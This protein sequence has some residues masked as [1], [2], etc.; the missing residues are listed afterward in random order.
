L[1]GDSNWNPIYDN[2]DPLK[3]IEFQAYVSPCC[4]LS[5]H[6]VD[7]PSNCED[8]ISYDKDGNPTYLFEEYLHEK[9]DPI[10]IKNNENPDGTAKEQIAL[11]S[12][13]RRFGQGQYLIERSGSNYEYDNTTDTE[14][15]WI[16]CIANGDFN[17]LIEN[18][19]NDPNACYNEEQLCIAWRKTVEEIRFTAW[20][21]NPN[22]TPVYGYH[23]FS[24]IPNFKESFDLLKAFLDKTGT[25]YQGFTN[26]NLDDHDSPG[27]SRYVRNAYKQVHFWN[28]D[29]NYPDAT[30]FENDLLEQVE[31]IST[32]PEL[33]SESAP[34]FPLIDANNYWISNSDVC[35][36]NTTNPYVVDKT[37]EAIWNSYY[38]AKLNGLDNGNHGSD[39]ANREIA[40]IDS[41]FKTGE[42]GVL[43]KLLEINC[44]EKGNLLEQR[45]KE[46]YYQNG[47]K[48]FDNPFI[49]Y[50][51]N[52]ILYKHFMSGDVVSP[53][54]PIP[55]FTEEQLACLLE[56]YNIRCK[57]LSLSLLDK[58]RYFKNDT[59]FDPENQPGDKKVLEEYNQIIEEYVNL[60]TN[61][62]E[63]L[64]ED[65]CEPGCEG[66]CFTLGDGSLYGA[67][68]GIGFEFLSKVEK[69][70]IKSEIFSVLSN[71]YTELE[72][73]IT[74]PAKND[75]FLDLRDVYIQH[76]SLTEPIDQKH[77]DII[78][79]YYS[80]MPHI[81]FETIKQVNDAIIEFNKTIE[82]GRCELI[83]KGFDYTIAA[84]NTIFQ[85]SDEYKKNLRK[86]IN[87]IEDF[88]DG[89]HPF[90]NHLDHYDDRVEAFDF[91]YYNNFYEKDRIKFYQNIDA[92]DFFSKEKH[93]I[94]PRFGRLIISNSWGGKSLYHY[95]INSGEVKLIE[96]RVESAHGSIIELVDKTD[97]LMLVYLADWFVP[98]SSGRDYYKNM[99]SM[100]L[101]GFPVEDSTAKRCR[102][103]LCCRTIPM[104]PEPR[105]P[106]DLVRKG[107]DGHKGDV[108]LNDLRIQIQKCKEDLDFAVDGFIEE[109]ERGEFLADLNEELVIEYTE[110]QKYHY[111]LYYYDRQGNLTKT[112]PPRGVDVKDFHL[113]TE[114]PEH[115]FLSEYA[116]D[117]FGNVTEKKSPD[118]TGDTKYYYNDFGQLRFSQ[119][120]QQL[121]ESKY[122]YTIYDDLGR[123]IEVGEA[124]NTNAAKLHEMV[125]I[126]FNQDAPPSHRTPYT[127]Q[128]NITFFVMTVYDEE[129]IAHESKGASGDRA[130]YADVLRLALIN[131]PDECPS[132]IYSSNVKRKYL[133][134]RINFVIRDEDGQCTDAKLS[135]DESR[136]D[137]DRTITYYSYDIHGNVDFIV[138]NVPVHH[139]KFDEN[140]VVNRLV[141][142]TRY[143]YDLISGK[144][145]E[146][147]Y[148]DKLAESFK[149]KYEYDEQ[150][151]LVE[152]K[153]SRYG[154]FWES[155]ARYYYY[156]HGPLRRVEMGEDQLQG[157]DY[158]YTING[159]LKA[160]NNSNKNL[161]EPGSDGSVANS[162]DANYLKYPKDAFGY[163]LNYN[164]EDYYRLND[165]YSLNSDLS[166][167]ISS[168]ISA[169]SR[170]L[171]FPNLYNGNIAAVSYGFG[172]DVISKF[173]PNLNPDFIG[174]NNSGGIH[175][176]FQYDV[177]NRLVKSYEAFK[178]SSDFELNSD[179]RYY[180]EYEYDAS[181]N[182]LELRRN[183]FDY[184]TDQSQMDNL[185]YI[186][187]NNKNQLH[188]VTE[189]VNHGQT[190]EIKDI[191]PIKGYIDPGGG[192]YLYDNIGNLTKDAYE[193]LDEITWTPDGKIKSYKFD[194][195]TPCEETEFKCSIEF[196]YDALGNRVRKT[197][198]KGLFEDGQHV[199][200]PDP[201]C[202]D[203]DPN[204]DNLNS[205][206]FTNTYYARGANGK[207]KA[208]YNLIYDNGLHGDFDYTKPDHFKDEDPTDDDIHY[209]EYGV[210][211][212]STNEDIPE[213]E[214]ATGTPVELFTPEYD[215]FLAIYEFYLP[216][217]SE[218][219]IYGSGAQGRFA[220]KK[221]DYAH[222][223]YQGP[224][225]LCYSDYESRI[226]GLKSY[227]ITD[228]LGNPRVIL[229]DWR[230][231]QYTFNKLAT[232]PNISHSGLGLMLDP[233]EMNNYFPF[234]MLKEGMFAKSGNG[235]RY[236]FNGM[237]RDN[238]TKGFGNDLSTFFRGY[239]PRLGRWK[240]VDPVTKAM[241]SAYVGFG[242]NPIVFIDPRGD[243]TSEVWT[244]S[245]TGEAIFD[246]YGKD[247]KQ[248]D[249]LTV[250]ADMQMGFNHMG[251]YY[252]NYFFNET[253]VY[254][255]GSEFGDEGWYSEEE[256]EYINRDW[257][258]GQVLP[259]LTWWEAFFS[260]SRKWE[261]YD[262]DSDGYLTGTITYAGTPPDVTKGGAKRAG[263]LLLKSLGVTKKYGQFLIKGKYSIYFY[264][265]KEGKYYIG[266]ARNGVIARYGSKKAENLKV[267]TFE[268][269]DLTIK[270]NA[271]ALGVEQA[272]IKLNGGAI[273]TNK[274]TN[275]VNKIN[276]T[277]NNIY[278]RVGEKWLDKN[279]K[280]WR[281]KFKLT[282]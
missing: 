196:T 91:Q 177:L 230:L 159:W 154:K 178:G 118:E 32:D 221:P 99:I 79:Y 54:D 51:G 117:S 30:Y 189:S 256:Y 97:H 68:Q 149:H 128:H 253:R 20:E 153:T 25:F 78:R 7:V 227:E 53:P 122:S 144:V 69:K 135:P 244:S 100:P 195:L 115:T 103:Q 205:L 52:R 73:S 278:R 191:D 124:E 47:Y 2:D 175:N 231:E 280:D 228:H 179:N 121:S 270:N 215:A 182:I 243:D 17:I 87:D 184:G 211:D 198:I 181:G 1:E 186:Y 214:T 267:V 90:D 41:Y 132:D 183:V 65:P 173:S 201:C 139:I 56:D 155:D 158:T 71:R 93:L 224:P 277:V 192:Y 88:L 239:D 241:E 176:L 247:A 61:D 160:V 72:E 48:V 13:F 104:Q 246:H 152:V 19:L 168:T 42:L 208:V 170:D 249:M 260:E 164:N 219:Y 109:I 82:Q 274:K 190:F 24:E 254:H 89:N 39:E 140:K 142:E 187:N 40:E 8:L 235:Y 46:F 36:F 28:N 197:L 141:T 165:N 261:G 66:N 236:G 96:E 86:Y 203:T 60:T 172:D 4:T 255:E 131:N 281:T 114:S 113:L 200:Y 81:R 138:Q 213:W 38:A 101:L 169:G 145:N 133:R 23:G 59:N 266:K 33:S 220:S 137:Y 94:D 26:A 16:D 130:H 162:I 218:W 258:N 271:T 210:D 37:M 22:G 76:H 232:P 74:D 156:P 108:I 237:E 166:D 223:L 157:L 85:D 34:E 102:R 21:V 188:K 67:V 98:E 55:H 151:R 161:I 107:V 240:S 70:V 207:V 5:I 225:D 92:I 146:V 6:E 238:E 234:G 147:E 171:T 245:N 83:F 242:N 212:N 84:N 50:S 9:Y 31:M 209:D 252:Q 275:L 95:E 250:H 15:K 112:V 49:L 222:V 126:T 11:K 12:Y 199:P 62:F 134:N 206:S 44:S 18:M 202:D 272:L 125:D 262:I 174:R 276:S 226:I 263:Q 127:E 257:H 27:F 216:K 269:L 45:I 111:T 29:Y 265:N 64:Y 136:D 259:K 105:K 150:N 229:S 268:G 129:L 251:G 3:I 77:E 43:E 14:E 193:G 106:H 35:G 264:K 148:C 273:S 163:V 75:L 143:S 119:N 167:R 194:R 279:I 110:S 204:N 217:L 282:D 123:V 57:D 233:I 63:I 180:S 58:V 80:A 120:A 248:G 185:S 116:F 10:Y